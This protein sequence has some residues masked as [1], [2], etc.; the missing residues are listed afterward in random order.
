MKRLRPDQKA[1]L[2]KGLAAKAEYER[3]L[4]ENNTTVE[5]DMA[6]LRRFGEDCRYVGAIH[7]ELLRQYPDRWVA[8]YLK[9]VIAV[10][11]THEELLLEVSSL[12]HRPGNVATRF[13]HTNPPRL[14]V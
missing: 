11:S 2:A 1:E 7:D 9:E 14:I 3:Y 10:A 8:V 13:M 5:E 12:G 6:D 4:A